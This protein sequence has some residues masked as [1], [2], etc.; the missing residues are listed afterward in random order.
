LALH[1]PPP[2]LIRLGEAVGKRHDAGVP[3]V[4]LV[5]VAG[6]LLLLAPT[7]PPAQATGAARENG[8]PAPRRPRSSAGWWI[9]ALL[10]GLLSFRFGMEGFALAGG[11]LLALLRLAATLLSFWPFLSAARRQT[12]GA[13]S[14]SGAGARDFGSGAGRPARMTRREALEVLG[15]D[16]QATPEDVHREYRRLI[17]K[18]HPDLGGST[19]LAAKVN[20]AKDVLS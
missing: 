20:E 6:V 10:L 1:A 16:A 3:V 11:V 19:Y 15:L 8:A 14:A 7:R 5:L 9:A 18:I 4:L 13:G 2:K 17:K 12:T